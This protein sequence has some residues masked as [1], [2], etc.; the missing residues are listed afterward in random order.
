[1]LRIATMTGAVAALA[2]TAS[3]LAAGGASA[4]STGYVFKSTN[5]GFQITITGH[6]D[7]HVRFKA[8]NTLDRGLNCGI[9]TVNKDDPAKKESGKFQ[10]LKGTESAGVL[11]LVTY[12]L[13]EAS[14]DCMSNADN[15]FPT[16]FG[17]PGAPKYH[18]QFT[19]TILVPKPAQPAPP[20]P[21]APK[22]PKKVQYK[23]LKI[24]HNPTPPPSQRSPLD[25]FLYDMGS[26][27]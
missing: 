10:L 18:Y 13:T 15:S 9:W 24:Q 20:P 27:N 17:N 6:T 14:F 2:L 26:S 4:T 21:P 7:G 23:P 22:P 12:G 19:K 8:V 1:M 16:P 11:T 25:Q 3:A 5:G